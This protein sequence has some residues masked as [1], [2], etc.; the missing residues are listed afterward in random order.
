MSTTGGVYHD[1]LRDPPYPTR[2]A[3]APTA[4]DAGCGGAAVSRP[5][6]GDS[7]KPTPSMTYLVLVTVV[8]VVVVF[9]FAFTHFP[10]AALH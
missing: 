1:R 10:P 2:P 3:V 8:V 6:T 5:A 4:D 9:V 7:S